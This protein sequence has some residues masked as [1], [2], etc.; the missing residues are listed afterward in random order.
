MWQLSI[1]QLIYFVT[2]EF[3]LFIDKTF[4]QLNPEYRTLFLSRSSTKI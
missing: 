1:W 2:A 4:K 3:F